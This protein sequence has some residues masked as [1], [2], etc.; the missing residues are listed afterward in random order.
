M[1]NGRIT[2]NIGKV[3]NSAKTGNQFFNIRAFKFDV[4]LRAT[5]C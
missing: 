2:P 5:I 1:P 3:R 4:L